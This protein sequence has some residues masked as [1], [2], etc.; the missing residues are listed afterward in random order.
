MIHLTTKAGDILLCH[1]K[2]IL[3]ALSP[4]D[5][6]KDSGVAGGEGAIYFWAKL[7]SGANALLPW[8]CH[9]RFGPEGACTALDHVLPI[10]KHVACCVGSSRL[11]TLCAD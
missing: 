3:D 10:V 9:I 7:P 6:G 1:R 5:V 2:A 4:L 11:L 8:C